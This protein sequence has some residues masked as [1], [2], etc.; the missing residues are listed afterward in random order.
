MS[1]TG[2]TLSSTYKSLLR[3]NDDSNGVDTALE[4]VTDGE[5][6]ASSISISDDQLKVQ[7][8]NDNVAGTFAVANLSGSNIFSVNANDSPNGVKVGTGQVYA[9]TQYAHFSASYLD[10]TC[11]GALANTHYAVPFNNTTTASGVIANIGLGTDTDPATS[12][13]ISDSAMDIIQCYWYVPDNIVIQKVLWWHAADTAT[14]DTTRAHLMSY[15]VVTTAGA[16]SGDLSNGAVIAASSDITNAGYEQAYYNEMS[17]ATPA[18]T[19]G[20]VVLF[21]F[22]SDSVNSDYTINATIKYYIY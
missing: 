19:A 7:P 6:T 15:D 17:I 9:N 10:A 5:G 3:V 22:R 12:L 20:K 18:V 4:A 21:A 2:K 1:L 16:T 8:Q 11:A 14:G 13:T